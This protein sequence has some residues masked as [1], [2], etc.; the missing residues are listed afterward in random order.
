MIVV[1]ENVDIGRSERLELVVFLVLC[2]V[3][4]V[5]IFVVVV[6]GECGYVL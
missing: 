3:D 6:R 2:F 1:W 4:E 5:D